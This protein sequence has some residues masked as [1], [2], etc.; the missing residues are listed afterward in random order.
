ME[1]QDNLH[2]LAPMTIRG[3]QW[4]NRIVLAPK[5]GMRII[6]GE[7][8]QQMHDMLSYYGMGHP[9]EVIIGET[10]VSEQAGRSVGDAYDF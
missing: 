10:P 8:E 4:K 9:A 1:R 6:D 7:M 3:K 2:M 5:G